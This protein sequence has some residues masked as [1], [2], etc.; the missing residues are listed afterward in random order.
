VNEAAR[1]Q[2]IGDLRD[3]VVGILEADGSFSFVTRAELARQ[4][5]A[6]QEPPVG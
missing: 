2:G 3:V 4:Q 6:G 5:Q 1:Q